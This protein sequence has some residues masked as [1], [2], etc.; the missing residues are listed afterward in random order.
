MEPPEFTD[1]DIE[2]IASATNLET[3]EVRDR[4]ES[5]LEDEWDKEAEDSL[6]TLKT[7]LGGNSKEAKRTVRNFIVMEFFEEELDMPLLVRQ[8]QE[9]E[10]V[11]Q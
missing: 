10:E 8:G 5:R 3:T 11:W 4:I 2:V 6:N 1:E 7:M 9:Q